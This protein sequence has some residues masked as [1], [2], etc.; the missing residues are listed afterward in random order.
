M[1]GWWDLA[2]PLM[3]SPA[4]SKPLSSQKEKNNR[5]LSMEYSETRKDVGVIQSRRKA[6]C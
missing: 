4:V 6:T 3:G 2:L 1:S 5:K